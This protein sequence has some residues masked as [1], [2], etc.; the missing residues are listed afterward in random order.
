MSTLPKFFMISKS[1]GY[2]FYKNTIMFPEAQF[3]RPVNMVSC[4]LNV[5]I[6]YVS[7]H[8][9]QQADIYGTLTR[10][11][12]THFFPFKSTFTGYEIKII[13]NGSEI[14]VPG[15]TF[16]ECNPHLLPSGSPM[17]N[18][19][20]ALVRWQPKP[21]PYS[22][23]DIILDAE[24]P[25]API[26]PTPVAPTLLESTGPSLFPSHIKK[27]ILTDSIN[28]NEACSITGESIN[29]EN[30]CI[31]SCG[32]VFTKSGLSRWFSM[33]SSNQSCPICRQK[34]SLA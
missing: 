19:N 31:T 27:L 13:L 14:I 12:L 5:R 1:Q 16:S 17:I 2:K 23:A 11:S 25:I 22:E 21:L 30:A 20:T 3:Y 28:K 26:A 8:T 29:Q 24:L 10:D 33:A 7:K 6:Q 9:S 15:I 4:L 34:C 18:P 32:H